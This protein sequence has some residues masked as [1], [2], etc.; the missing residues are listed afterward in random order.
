[1]PLHPPA[2]ERL[3]ASAETLGEVIAELRV[4]AKLSQREL[5]SRAAAHTALPA[6]LVLSAATHWERDRRVPTPAHLLLL[7][8]VLLPDPEVA[9][10]AF[11]RVL[12]AAARRDPGYTPGL[13]LV[14]RGE[15]KFADW[16]QW[17]LS[18]KR[19]PGR[20]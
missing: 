9:G 16:E 13:E 10:G 18:F 20:G 1:M 2:P 17:A 8:K 5:I 19:A 14:R 6:G 15:W 12:Q 7:L 3:L 4:A 11:E